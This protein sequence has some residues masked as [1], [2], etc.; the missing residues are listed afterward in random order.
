MVNLNWAKT[1]Q[2]VLTRVLAAHAKSTAW[3][4]DGTWYLFYERGDRGVWLATSKDRRTWTNAQDDPVLA[5]GLN[6]HDGQV[7]YASVAEAHGLPW[8][9]L[10]DLLG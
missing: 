6:T 10:A 1:H 2:D 9:S 4:E 8:I 5:L 7:T 3:F